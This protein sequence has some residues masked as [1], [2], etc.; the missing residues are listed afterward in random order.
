V[1]AHFINPIG[2]NFHTADLSHRNYRSKVIVHGETHLREIHHTVLGDGPAVVLLHGLGGSSLAWSYLAPQL[3]IA[4]YR[5]FMPDLPGHGHSEKAAHE[6]HYHEHEIYTDLL[7]WIDSLELI[8]PIFLIGHSF[9]GLMSL[10]FS[11]DRPG[12]VRSMTLIDPLYSPDQFL[13]GIHWISQRPSLILKALSKSPK[14]LLSASTIV[15]FP[16]TG[17][18]SPEIRRQIARDLKRADPQVFH[19]LPSI[20][21]MTPRL[22]EIQTATQV[23]W[24]NRDM[25]L[26]PSSFPKLVSHMPN[27]INRKIKS[28]GH[29]PHLTHPEL[30]NRFILD[31]IKKARVD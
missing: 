17:K 21:D 14:R 3:A 13:P 28:T 4:G 31:F 27:A 15:D 12:Q 23:I 11:L 16:L 2:Y 24:G 18:L 5:V 25:T 29:Q 22:C 7:K 8:G 10:H 26:K 6:D 30:V 19:I 9:G 1:V 20:P